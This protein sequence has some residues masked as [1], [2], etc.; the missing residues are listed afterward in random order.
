MKQS[1]KGL[2]FD[3]NKVH[4]Y[5]R[6]LGEQLWLWGFYGPVFRASNQISVRA[7]IFGL[8]IWA[9]LQLWPILTFH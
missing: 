6:Y 2:D 5:N 3:C 8:K 7:S 1:V 4:G 9:S